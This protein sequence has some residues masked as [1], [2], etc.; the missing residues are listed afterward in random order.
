MNKSLM[1]TLKKRDVNPIA[2]YLLLASLLIMQGS[3]VDTVVKTQPEN[4]GF[5]IVPS[6]SQ[7]VDKR[8]VA[9]V[10]G[11][12]AYHIAPLRNPVNDATDLKKALTGLGF[13]V[14]LRT[15]ANKK[16]M[17]TAMREFGKQLRRGNTGLFYYS[18]HGLQLENRNFLVPIG[19]DIKNEADVEFESV[20]ANRVLR[21]MEQAN[22]GVNLVFLDACRDNPYASSFKSLTRGLA[23]MDS[24]SGTLIAYATA[25]GDVA[26]DGTGRNGTFTKH[27]LSALGTMSHLSVADLLTEVTGKVK[28]ETSGFQNP[29]ISMSLG[30]RFC[31]SQCGGFQPQPVMTAS[32]SNVTPI[33]PPR[34]APPPVQ[35]PIIVPPPPKPKSKVFRDRLKEGSLGPKMV[36]IPA[37]RFQMGDIQGGGDSDEKPVHWVSV[38]KFAMGKFEVTFAEYDKFAQATGLKKPNDR[39]WGRGNRPVI[40]VSWHDAVAYAEWLS[41]QTG[42][43]YRL[44]TEAEWEYAARA[45]TETKY[46]WGNE[47]GTNKA[48][49]RNSHCGDHFEYTAPVGSFAA[50]PFGL[51]DTVGNVWEWTCSEFESKYSGKEK[52]CKS[53]NRANNSRLSLRGGSWS[54][55]A[56]YVRSAGRYRWWP[57]Y[58]SYG[59][60]FRVVRL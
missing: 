55:D 12:E 4:R 7:A 3:C 58:R 19:A 44:P 32:T 37:G 10:I 21:Q 56:M 15:N 53:K 30:T 23:R 31:F 45:G 27:F 8:R 16:A 22:N 26:E 52:K 14:I 40:N 47:I 41:Q 18:G 42:K 28:A 17:I 33:S 29:W 49:C 11:N 57:T 20:D 35:T 50:N 6:T 51:Y 39:G 13:K 1:M 48:N 24:P 60:G 59:L 25:P 38:G 2:K 36:R 9:L 46:W 54:F 5:L 43:Q 34:I